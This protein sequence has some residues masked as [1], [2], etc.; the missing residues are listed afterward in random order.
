M[1]DTPINLLLVTVLAVL[2]LFYAVPRAVKKEKIRYIH[3]VDMLSMPDGL[4]FVEQIKWVRNHSGI[5]TN[6]QAN[7][8]LQLW[9]NRLAVT[10]V[11]ER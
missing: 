5:H 7:E 3:G 8:V 10:D 4:S 1:P 6:S 2:F 11:A 9:H